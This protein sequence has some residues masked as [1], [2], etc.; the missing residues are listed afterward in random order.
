M[1]KEHDKWYIH[2]ISFLYSEYLSSNGLFPLLDPE[3]DSKPYGYIVLCR[4]CFHCLRFRLRSLSHSICIVQE[5]VSESKSESE[6]GNGNKPLSPLFMST[7]HV[8]HGQL[9]NIKISVLMEQIL[10]NRQET[11]LSVDKRVTFLYPCKK[12]TVNTVCLGFS[13]VQSVMVLSMVFGEDY[14]FLFCQCLLCILM[15]EVPALSMCTH[16]NE[17]IPSTER[18]QMLQWA[19]ADMLM[20]G[21][22]VTN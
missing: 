13:S 9:S 10:K 19:C 1:T 11:E 15:M 21:N 7:S 14:G 6:S 18:V 5:S 17:G 20:R 4:T 16:I 2:L 12:E 8:I 3:S 22:P